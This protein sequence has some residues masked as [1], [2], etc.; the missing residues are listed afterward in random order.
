V[1]YPGVH[2]DAWGPSENAINILAYVL[3]D[4]ASI[5]VKPD[6]ARLFD[7][8]KYWA[9][10][11]NT[12]RQHLPWPKK[13]RDVHVGRTQSL[14]HSLRPETDEATELEKKMETELSHIVK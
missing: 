5:S 4:F 3:S 6:Y 8:L 9:Y 14:H 1:W 10:P 13:D 11:K 2:A 12:E 7:Q